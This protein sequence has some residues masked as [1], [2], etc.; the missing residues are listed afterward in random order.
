[1]TNPNAFYLP[2]N[3][4]EQPNPQTKKRPIN[5]E[6][7]PPEVVDALK[8]LG[9]PVTA[10]AEMSQTDRIEYSVP[11]SLSQDISYSNVI[12]PSQQLVDGFSQTLIANT[13]IAPQPYIPYLG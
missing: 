10:Q 7:L 13:P 6:G 9:Y 1:M 5:T 4:E 2:L 11:K 3:G 8:R 12:E